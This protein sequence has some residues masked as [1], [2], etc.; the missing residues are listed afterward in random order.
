MRRASKRLALIRKVRG[1]EG[2]IAKTPGGCAPQKSRA[3]V[4]LGSA[5][6]KFFA[7]FPAFLIQALRTR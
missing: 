6:G 7:F 1:G 4:K 3:R 2:G 5:L